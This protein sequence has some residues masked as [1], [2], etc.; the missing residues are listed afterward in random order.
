MHSE[1]VFIM[2]RLLII[3]ILTLS[4][5]SLT[6]ADDITDFEIEGI[7]IGDS[8]LDY[9]TKNKIKKGLYPKSKKFAYSEH[10]FKNSKK[11]DNFRFH[12]KTKDKKIIIHGMS[13]GIFYENNINECYKK[14]IE[15]IRE[16]E[17]SFP[18]GKKYVQGKLKHPSDSTGKSF[19]T[20]TALNF[21]DGTISIEC[22]DWSDKITSKKN[23]T[24]NLSIIVSTKELSHWIS[25]DAR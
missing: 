1:K 7:S 16:L 23:W 10:I 3:L 5:Q 17:S 12:Y 8:A 24:D 22:T 14:E 11:Y 13:G 19:Y 25:N 18:S 21:D 15:I 20:Y 4:F 2:K 6:R 9:F